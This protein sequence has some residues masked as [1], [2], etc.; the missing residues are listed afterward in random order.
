MWAT[1]RVVHISTGCTT[2]VRMI[3]LCEVI[4]CDE[5]R[6]DL[7]SRH[8]ADRYW[9]VSYQRRAPHRA[10]HECRGI[11][12]LV[13]EF[14]HTLPAVNGLTRRLLGSFCVGAAVL[15]C[16]CVG[17]ATEARST[18]REVAPS[19]PGATRNARPTGVIKR[20]VAVSQLMLTVP[21][22]IAR[23]KK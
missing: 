20:A 11:I 8:G 15:R 1:Q 5:S 13:A 12:S 23:V 2:A 22:V 17:A 19:K 10:G 6:A 7:Q 3:E 14:V 9:Q 21:V 18:A 4:E 16:S